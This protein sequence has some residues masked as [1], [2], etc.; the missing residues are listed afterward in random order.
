MTAPPLIPVIGYLPWVVVLGA[1][2]W[3]L[4]VE[5]PFLY[6]PSAFALK[7]CQLGPWNNRTYVRKYE[8]NGV[9]RLATL[10]PLWTVRH[11]A[12]S[13]YI[14]WARRFCSFLAGVRTRL[15]DCLLTTGEDMGDMTCSHL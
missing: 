4:L 6:A 10:K 8:M 15:F 9:C 13:R 1:V 3:M 7:H 5:A 14:F 11:V 2:P 12:Y